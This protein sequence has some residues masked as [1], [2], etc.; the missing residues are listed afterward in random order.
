MESMMEH[1]AKS[2]NKDPGDVRKA[3]FYQKGQVRTTHGELVCDA[4]QPLNTW[5]VCL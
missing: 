5:G 3:N 1:V 4:V 2:L